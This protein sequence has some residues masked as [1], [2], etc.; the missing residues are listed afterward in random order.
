MK[1]SAG[2]ENIH[3]PN[4][5]IPRNVKTRSLL[6]PKLLK[7]N[8]DLPETIEVKKDKECS[9]VFYPEMIVD[10]LGKPY[11]FKSQ[12]KT[13]HIGSEAFIP[14]TLDAL[15]KSFFIHGLTPI[16]N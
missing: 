14:I 16:K 12:K 5:I 2:K 15:K 1:R 4:K 3:A 7:V 10:E 8:K 6:E 9:K 11:K 13:S